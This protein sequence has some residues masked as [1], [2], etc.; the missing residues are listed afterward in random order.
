MEVAYVFGSCRD[1][2]FSEHRHTIGPCDGCFSLGFVRA[3]LDTDD[4]LMQTVLR[5]PQF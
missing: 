2:H 5:L 1:T 3:M 4:P